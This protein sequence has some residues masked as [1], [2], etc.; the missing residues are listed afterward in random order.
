MKQIYGPVDPVTGYVLPAPVP[1]PPPVQRQRDPYRAVNTIRNQRGASCQ[2]TSMANTGPGLPTTRIDPS[3]P[4][5][6]PNAWTNGPGHHHRH[7]PQGSTVGY[8]SIPG[9]QSLNIGPVSPNHY[10]TARIPR[11]SVSSRGSTTINPPLTPTSSTFSRGS[12]I[13]GTP[14]RSAKGSI[15]STS[16]SSS[17]LIGVPQLWQI[18]ANFTSLELE[19][20]SRPNESFTVTMGNLKPKTKREEVNDVLEQSVGTYLQY[21]MTLV[22]SREQTCA[23]ITFMDKTIANQVVHSLNDYRFKDRKLQLRLAQV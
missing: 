17:T 9:T 21:E 13:V 19:Q 16:N 2:P 8:H 7:A 5:I 15:S 1:C 12:S 10:L 4:V 22:E 20:R 14:P 6:N 23:E 11:M 18:D 3:Q